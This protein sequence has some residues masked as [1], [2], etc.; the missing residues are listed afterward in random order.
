MD[1]IAPTREWKR[2]HEHEAAEVSRERNQTAYRAIEPY[3]SA[4]KRG[5]LTDEQRDAARRFYV[6][7]ASAVHGADVRENDELPGTP[8]DPD[9]PAR[10]QYASDYIYVTRNMSKR[11]KQAL[12][13]FVC[14]EVPARDIGRLY[15]TTKSHEAAKAVGM[16]YVREALDICAFLW[17]IGDAARTRERAA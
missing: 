4:H 3:R 15:I 17:G 2:R 10:E 6:T 16:A 12:E 11:A 7:Y 14:E 8:R 9:Y 1:T 13:L 5:D